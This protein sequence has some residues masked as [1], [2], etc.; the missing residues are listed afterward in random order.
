M[1]KVI[2]TSVVLVL[3]V[4]TGAFATLAGQIQNQITNIG[5]VT[6]VELMHGDQQANSLQNLVVDNQQCATGI[7]SAVAHEGFFASIGQAAEACGQCALVGAVQNLVLG[8]TQAQ[9]VGEGVGPKAQLQGVGLTATQTLAKADGAGGANALHTI[10]AQADQTATNP[11]GQLTESSTIMGMQTSS[12][13]G[14]AG[15]N[16]YV[17]S[18]MTVTTSQ[19]QGSL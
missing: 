19:T 1:S 16:G 17:D 11:A 9:E 3:V 18:G 8:G 7:C 12:L 15:A 4:S 2:A 6:D 14:Q 5:L 10:V 13:N